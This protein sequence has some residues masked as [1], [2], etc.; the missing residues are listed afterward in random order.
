MYD[1]KHAYK[2]MKKHAYKHM[3]KSRIQMYD[4]KHA[5]KHMKKTRIQTYEKNPAY[6]HMKKTRIQITVEVKEGEGT[7]LLLLTIITHK[8][9][10]Y[11]VDSHT[12][13]L[14]LCSRDV[15][16]LKVCQYEKNAHYKCM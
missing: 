7:Q 9:A 4:K 8:A 15:D 10:L 14:L 5:Y 13:G 6:K 2:H 11:R 1:K 12:C 16:N 3:K